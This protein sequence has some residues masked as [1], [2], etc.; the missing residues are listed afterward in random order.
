MSEPSNRSNSK[1]YCRKKTFV[2]NLRSNKKYN[3]N[4]KSFNIYKPNIYYSKKPNRIAS[5]KPSKRIAIIENTDLNPETLSVLGKDLQDRLN[6]LMTEYKNAEDFKVNAENTL[7]ISK[8][9]RTLLDDKTVSR[10]EEIDKSL[11]QLVPIDKWEEWSL[12]TSIR[13]ITSESLC[14]ESAP[15]RIL[16]CDN[17]MNSFS[18]KNNYKNAKPRD[19]YLQEF[20]EKREINNRIK[21]IDMKLS[22]LRQRHIKQYGVCT[23]EE[24][25]VNS[26]LI[27]RESKKNL[28]D[29]W[30]IMMNLIT[31]FKKSKLGYK[32]R[33]DQILKPTNML[34]EEI[35]NLLSEP[36]LTTGVGFNLNIGKKD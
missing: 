28:R 14:A 32:H 27:H 6:T 29:L 12:K 13:S 26:N 11:R 16:N 17:T 8:S 5:A 7:A 22:E 30:K 2:T 31:E 1:Q 25:M 19:K 35:T 33:V 36:L 34:F 9:S 10:I 23:E 15:S 20:A 3:E 21:E 4:N 24:K 18:L